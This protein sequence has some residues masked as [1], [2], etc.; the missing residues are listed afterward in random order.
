LNTFFTPIE[1]FFPEFG[2]KGV[3][4]GRGECVGLMSDVVTGEFADGLIMGD[5]HSTY[6]D[7]KIVFTG[8]CRSRPHPTR[9]DLSPLELGCHLDGTLT[10]VGD[11][12]VMHVKDAVCAPRGNNLSGHITMFSCD[13]HGVPGNLLFQGLQQETLFQ[14]QCILENEEGR[15]EGNYEKGVRE[16]HGKLSTAVGVYEG[17]WKS[18]VKCGVG[19]MTY[20]DGSS[21]EGTWVEG[22]WGDGVLQDSKKGGP[23]KVV[24]GKIVG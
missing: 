9:R 22:V 5:I 24:S 16:G 4:H 10:S 17:E 18:D 1:L 15:Y 11:R 23:K 2:L 8:S 19:K 7:G 12:I 6:D 21:F 20:K 14:G 13:E 3:P